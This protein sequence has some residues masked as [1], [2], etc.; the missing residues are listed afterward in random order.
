M[1][2]SSPSEDHGHGEQSFVD[3]VRSRT[4][5]WRTMTPRLRLVTGAA[6]AQVLVCAALLGLRNAGLPRTVISVQS[7]QLGGL[8]TIPTPVMWASIAGLACAWT[9]LLTSAMDGHPLARLV[10]LAAFTAVSAL[11]YYNLPLSG[12]SGAIEVALLAALRVLG[13]ETVIDDRRRG[14]VRDRGPRLA[15]LLGTFVLVAGLYGAFRWS[16]GGDMAAQG[17]FAAAVFEQTVVLAM[18]IPVLLLAGSEFGEWGEIVG[19]SVGALTARARSGVVQA[20]ILVAVASAV[21]GGAIVHH[22]GRLA[23]AALVAV[24]L[25]ALILRTRATPASRTVQCQQLRLECQ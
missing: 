10:G 13:L 12:A 6:V 22:G 19:E 3:A 25:A 17:N 15:R 11:L 5:S 1:S 23:V 9:Y 20:L 21:L 4:I 7:L 18:L 2:T 16:A 14:Q 24:V 8:I